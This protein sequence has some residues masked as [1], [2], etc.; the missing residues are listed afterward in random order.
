[1]FIYLLRALSAAEIIDELQRRGD[2]LRC[3]AAS[4]P[5]QKLF[6]V[7]KTRIAERNV[8]KDRLSAVI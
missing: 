7:S 8:G 6:A 3:K 5:H 1:M 4:L 2:E